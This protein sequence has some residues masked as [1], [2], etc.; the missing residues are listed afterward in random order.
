MELPLH[1]M[2]RELS[3]IFEISVT[4]AF[5]TYVFLLTDQCV[6]LGHY[7]AVFSR[8]RCECGVLG[9]TALRKLLKE[10]HSYVNMVDYD[11]PPIHRL[12]Y[13][14]FWVLNIYTELR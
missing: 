9:K 8:L 7:T 10:K 5:L 4:D 1:A 14:H 13:I 2:D 11:P 6:D 12:N 3:T